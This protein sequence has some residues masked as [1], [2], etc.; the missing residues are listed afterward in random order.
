MAPPKMMEVRKE[1]LLMSTVSKSQ[2]S[3]SS[4]ELESDFIPETKKI[5]MGLQYYSVMMENQT[6]LFYVY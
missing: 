6:Y 1:P 4:P 3:E 5:N 2:I